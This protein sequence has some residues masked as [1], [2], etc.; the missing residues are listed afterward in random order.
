MNS[1]YPETNRCVEGV[2]V[3]LRMRRL[4]EGGARGALAGLAIG[5]IALAVRS[6]GGSG[7]SSWA[8]GAWAALLGGGGG[9]AVGLLVGGAR[10]GSRLESARYLDVIG[11]TKDR[12]VSAEDF[13][14][15]DG[16]EWLRLARDECERFAAKLDPA[17]LV[18]AYLPRAIRYLPV[19]LIAIAL[20]T[21]L[22]R[23]ERPVTMQER[24]VVSDAAADVL[25]K[26]AEQL[27][28][29][30]PEMERLKEELRQSAE[31]IAAVDPEDKNRTLLRQLSG[32]EEMVSAMMS[33]RSEELAALADALRG[34]SDA[35]ADALDR[36]DV[37]TAGRELERLLER[38][39]EREDA[40]QAMK[41][42]AQ[43]I[44]RQTERMSSQEN[45]ELAKQMQEASQQAE[46]SAEMEKALQELAQLLQKQ[47]KQSADGKNAKDGKGQSDSGQ[48]EGD[49]RGSPGGGSGQQ[50][51]LSLEEI[52]DMIE[53]LK[54]GE[55]P[56]MA[57]GQGEQPSQGSEGEGSQGASGNPGSEMD[58]GTDPKLA[59]AQGERE[60]PAGPAER[61]E[62]LSTV[63]ETMIER[64]AAQDHGGERAS[65][66]YRQLYEA[67]A[68][69]A[70]DA[71]RGEE[72]P[73]GAR[74]VV[75]RYFYNIRPK[76]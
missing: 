61:P 8:T 52:R 6:F 69:A 46:Q 75:R 76:E 11:A 55:A 9:M 21:L 41:Q 15:Q 20:V 24:D 30:S 10:P 71:V 34:I 40:A 13:G 19:P 39:N 16:S 49:K 5:M 31:A 32:L 37:A 1:E 47:G 26:A 54:N 14:R 7:E 23:V 2:R 57:E 58:T 3:R 38:L 28:G 59:G 4:L 48:G 64:L 29:N 45:S 68:P 25:A 18:P 66:E 72:I 70:A 17:T 56:Q 44:G 73:L 35:A 60:K 62:G 12:F 74:G 51:Q 22:P 53:R 63:G 43:S 67:Y 65:R 27:R 50:R 36:G 33:G 42:L